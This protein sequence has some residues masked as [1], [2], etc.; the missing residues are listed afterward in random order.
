[1]KV[2]GTAK[3]EVQ[4][5]IAILQLGVVTTNPDVRRAQEENRILANRMVQALIEAGITQQD[6]ETSS[7]TSFPRYET[8]SAGNSVISAYEVRHIFRIKVRDIT[9][10]GEI[11]DLAFENGANVSESVS[12][13]VSQ[14]TKIYRYV[15]QLAVKD[16]AKKA[17]A[18]A[19][20]MQVCLVPIPVKVEEVSQ[21]LFPVPRYT[22]FSIQ[23][24]ASTPIEPQDVTINATVNLEYIY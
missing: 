17:Q 1:M 5:D 16:G 13:E 24:K 11:I 15:L 18:I 23:E 6:I 8:D 22:A 2:Q 3:K 14:Y 12:F 19:E 10:T 4:P 21:Q 7:Y 20:T 9:G